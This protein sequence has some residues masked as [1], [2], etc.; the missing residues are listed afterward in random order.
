MEMIH[1]QDEL[2]R[3]LTSENQRLQALLESKIIAQVKSEDES[4]STNE[5][6]R[7]YLISYLIFL[8]LSFLNITY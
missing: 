5:H 7:I 4:R 1:E 3:T 2:I 8:F 6:V